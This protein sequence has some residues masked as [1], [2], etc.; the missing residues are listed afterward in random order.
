M[1]KCLVLHGSPRKGNTYKATQMVMAEL[2]RRP[3][4][5][6]EEIHIRDLRLPFCRGCFSCILR[7]E[8]L[9]P[10]HAVMGSLVEKMM[11]ADALIVGAPIYILQINA[12]TKNLFEHLAYAFHRPR[13]FGKQAFVI[14]T[15]AAAA[16]K[17]G[18]CFLKETLYQIGYNHAYELPIA[19]WDAE[20]KPKDKDRKSIAKLASRFAA[21]VESG[22]D[23]QT[24]LKEAERC[25]NCGTC[26]GCDNCRTFCPDAAVILEGDI[27]R[28]DTDYC[29]GCGV[30]AV[31]CPRYAMVLAAEGQGR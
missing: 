6:F 19:C 14:T 16:A 11:Q 25:F 24:A 31:E 23:V 26:N 21:D 18:T 12:E 4:W 28:I 3:G 29:K 17:K 8:E 20:Y 1:K 15:T 27:R 13:F 22:L 2:A 9:C 30:C 7:D 10:H 5:E